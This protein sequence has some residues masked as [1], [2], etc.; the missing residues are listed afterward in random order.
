MTIMLLCAGDL[1]TIAEP[2]IKNREGTR[3]SSPFGMTS[4][5]LK[6]ILMAGLEPLRGFWLQI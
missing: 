3:L 6:E 1:G 4:G 2:L 5:A